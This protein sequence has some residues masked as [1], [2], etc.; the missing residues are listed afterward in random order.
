MHG[1]PL[2]VGWKNTVIAKFS[3]L[4]YWAPKIARTKIVAIHRYWFKKKCK[5]IAGNYLLSKYS[6]KLVHKFRHFGVTI[7]LSED[8]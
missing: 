3:M 4:K 7:C 5:L 6:G 2:A 8:T 1:G